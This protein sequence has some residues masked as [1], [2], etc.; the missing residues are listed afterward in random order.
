[1][2][3]RQWRSLRSR[4]LRRAV[5]SSLVAGAFSIAGTAHAANLFWDA[6]ITGAAGGG[7]GTWDAVALNWFNGTSN[8]AWNS[9]DDAIFGGT[10][11]TVTVGA[12]ITANSLQFS[13]TGYTLGG[14]SPLTITTGNVTVDPAVTATV[15]SGLLG[16]TQVLNKLGTGTLT[17]TNAGVSTRT[18]TTNVSA[19]T[20]A[21]TVS[22]TVN[23]LGTGAINLSGGTL[24]LT[25]W[26][27][28][29]PKVYRVGISHRG[30]LAILRV[31]ILP[32]R[33]LASAQTPRSTQPA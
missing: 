25:R 26:R 11:G 20:L 4:I 2:S 3:F 27:T 29:R 6:A 33:R 14:A 17:L 31:L 24:D 32:K 15:A 10:A 18:A 7:T 1:M 8:V 22:S 9:V 28:W 13:T 5:L 30:R 21:A 16:N 23:P 19:G 12:P